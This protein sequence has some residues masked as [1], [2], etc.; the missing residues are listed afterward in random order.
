MPVSK[1]GTELLTLDMQWWLRQKLRKTW[2]KWGK[3]NITLLLHS[4]A[5]VSVHPTDLSSACHFFPMFFSDNRSGDRY[6]TVPKAP[7]SWVWGAR[8]R[9]AIRQPDKE[10][11][12][13]VTEQSMALC[14]L[15]I[16]S[17]R[18]WKKSSKI[19]KIGTDLLSL[20][21]FW[22]FRTNAS[23]GPRRAWRS[24]TASGPWG[25]NSAWY[26]LQNEK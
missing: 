2:R 22:T 23:R 15:T 4:W 1:L 11:S 9:A 21:P 14:S 19:Q 12:P 5:P 8:T 13:Q 16:V 20:N 6:Q 10:V 18:L 3:P 25:A 26:T 17:N 24:I 7:F